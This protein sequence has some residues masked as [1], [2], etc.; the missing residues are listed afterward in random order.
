MKI[1]KLKSALT[2]EELVIFNVIGS[3]DSLFPNKYTP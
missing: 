1:I 2:E 3:L